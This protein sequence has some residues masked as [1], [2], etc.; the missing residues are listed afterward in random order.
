MLERVGYRKKP[1]LAPGELDVY[2]VDPCGVFLGVEDFVFW[3][4]K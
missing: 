2:E 4:V 1:F 3:V